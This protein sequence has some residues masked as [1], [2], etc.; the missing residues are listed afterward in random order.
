[1][2]DWIGVGLFALGT[3]I[4]ASGVVKRRKR[5]RTVVPAGA[6]RPEFAAMGEI[7]RPILL[8]FLAFFGLKMS[9]FYF[10]LGG[11]GLMSAVNYAGLMYLLV[12]YGG[13]VVLVTGKVREAPAVK[14]AEDSEAVVLR[15]AA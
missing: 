6:I 11:N 4:F 2:Y 12:A 15:R 10:A 5:A 13:Y 9:M 1:M 8:F 7:V 14:A 3:G